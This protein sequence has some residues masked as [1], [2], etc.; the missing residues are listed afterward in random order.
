MSMLLCSS[1]DVVRSLSDRWAAPG[2][3]QRILTVAWPCATREYDNY[4]FYHTHDIYFH[5]Y[6][7]ISD[8][9]TPP[10]PLYPAH[11]IAVTSCCLLTANDAIRLQHNII[12]HG[13]GDR[14]GLRKEGRYVAVLHAQK[15]HNPRI[16]RRDYAVF[17]DYGNSRLVI[18]EPDR[19]SVRK[20]IRML[21]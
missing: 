8:I 21:S 1:N 7:C 9:Q 4:F 14:R 19:L 16:R 20:V 2:E 6:A 18:Y 17:P 11:T 12:S 5:E 3:F 13:F 10:L 15:R